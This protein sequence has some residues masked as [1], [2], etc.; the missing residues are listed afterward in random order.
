MKLHVGGD[1]GIC[2]IL[3]DLKDTGQSFIFPF[4]F[5]LA[6]AEMRLILKDGNR[7]WQTYRAP[8]PVTATMPDT[9]LC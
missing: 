5:S 3:K 6:P 1:G 4:N 8:V 2:V 7:P 9:H